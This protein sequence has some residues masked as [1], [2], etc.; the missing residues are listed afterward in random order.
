MPSQFGMIGYSNDFFLSLQLDIALSEDLIDISPL[1]S[2]SSAVFP[3]DTPFKRSISMDFSLGHHLGLSS[4]QTTVHIGAHTDA[5]NHY[6]EQGVGI[7]KRDLHFYIGHCQ[8]IHVEIAPGQRIRPS[9]IKE[10]TSNRILF[11]T[12]SFPDPNNWNEDF[13]S[14]SAELIDFL[15][16]K[17]VILVGIDTPSIDPAN[18]KEL[19][20]HKS[21]AANDMAILEGIVLE[22]VKPGHYELIALPLKL[23]DADASPVRAILRPLEKL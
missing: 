10:I 8:V 13:N 20:S 12:N 2:E 11:K 15:K 14:L 21:I 9:H 17:N 19:E 16:N 23:K 7:A 18:D 22:H 3:G 1:I 6:S 4:I 5:P